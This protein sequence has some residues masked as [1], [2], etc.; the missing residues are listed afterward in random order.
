MT[1][2]LLFV[3]NTLEYGGTERALEE[4]V[5][6]LD[7]SRAEPIILCYGLNHYGEYLNET[8][9]LAVPIEDNLRARSVPICS[10]P[11]S[12]F[13]KHPR[14]ITSYLLQLFIQSY[15]FQKFIHS[16]GPPWRIKNYFRTRP[17][18]TPGR[19]EQI[20]RHT[21][22]EDIRGFI[23]YWRTFRRFRPHV[24]IFVNGFL[25]IFPW[26]AYLAARLAGTRRVVGIEQLIADPFPRRPLGKG[27]IEAARGFAG[28]HARQTFKY[29]LQGVLSD[30]TVCVSE[31][32]RKRLVDD[33]RFPTDKTVKIWN[34][35]DL[36]RFG[37]PIDE[38]AVVRVK[39]K[40][41]SDDPV[42]VCIA[43]LEMRKGIHLLLEALAHLLKD[44]PACKC[45]L[46]GEGP[47]RQE[48][49]KRASE[50]G[51]TSAAIFV[52][53][54]KD[55]R[56]YLEAADLFVLPSFKE[57]LPLSLVEAMAYGLPA[58]VTDVG[59]NAEVVLQGH[60]GLVVEPG[61]VERLTDAIKH[62]LANGEE[63]RRMGK[64]GLE[65][66]KEFDL[67]LLM[68]RLQEVLLDSRSL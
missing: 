10:S 9:N 39:L 27:I 15:L 53:H 36:R 5:V 2:R 65:R 62:L 6:R 28:W 3:T 42:I 4:L 40:I 44:F 32:V 45:L 12:F 25:S 43:R 21:I 52:G 54:A 14:E 50:L 26:Y 33:Y 63:R 16:E 29:W 67:D 46:V 34:G 38:G 55:V 68:S 18:R 31:A 60:N 7:R 57:G 19:I 41:G 8:R 58:V 64:N 17:Q 66:A 61:S 47:S 37:V 13:S 59:G 11:E 56:P 23:D 20:N 24:T 49:I 30:Q 1:T 35:A 48:L 22:L 51:L